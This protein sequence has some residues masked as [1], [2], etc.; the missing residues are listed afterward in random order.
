M[1]C[2]SQSNTGKKR[3]S[4]ARREVRDLTGS[5]PLLLT[6]Q[7]LA[8]LFIGNDNLRLELVHSCYRRVAAI[9]GE[10]GSRQTSG[11]VLSEF[12]HFHASSSLQK[13]NQ[14]Q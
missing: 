5:N 10:G 13:Q 3:K 6:S 8:L 9:N 1:I 2:A 12:L 7:G 11:Y 4:W 14:L